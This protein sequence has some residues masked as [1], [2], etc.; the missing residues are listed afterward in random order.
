MRTQQSDSLFQ[1]APARLLRTRVT[2][3]VL[4]HALLA[5][6]PRERAAVHSESPGSL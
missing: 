6:F 2:A 3:L 5:E 1:F 4:L